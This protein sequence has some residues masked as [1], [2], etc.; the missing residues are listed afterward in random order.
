VLQVV[1]L[2]VKDVGTASLVLQVPWKPSD[3]EPPA[4]MLAL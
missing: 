1:P 4:G 2:T 3:V